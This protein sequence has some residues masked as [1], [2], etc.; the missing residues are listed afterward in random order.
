M[1][2]GAG[3]IACCPHVVSSAKSALTELAA[4]SPNLWVGVVFGLD[5]KIIEPAITEALRSIM[6][7]IDPTLRC[8]GVGND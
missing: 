8:G 6:A 7:S 1:G 5:T 3:H 2:A 4:H